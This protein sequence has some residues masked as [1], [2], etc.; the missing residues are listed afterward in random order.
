MSDLRARASPVDV[1]L[2][3]FTTCCSAC[4]LFFRQAQTCVKPVTSVHEHHVPNMHND[5]SRSASLLEGRWTGA[6]PARCCSNTCL[7]VMCLSL[8]ASMADDYKPNNVVTLHD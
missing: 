5:K 2:Q 6:A 8:R 7:S 3:C 4:C 1:Y